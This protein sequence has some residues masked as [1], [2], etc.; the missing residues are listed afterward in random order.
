MLLYPNPAQSTINLR[1]INDS[2]GNM[3]VNILDMMGRIIKTKQINKSQNLLQEAF[4]ISILP[5][6]VYT[7]QV[8]MGENAAVVGKFIKQ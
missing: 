3:V 4:N 2:T 1:L 8:V 7:M 5:K 6:G